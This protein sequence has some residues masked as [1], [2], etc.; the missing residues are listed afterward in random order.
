[1]PSPSPVCV[2]PGERASVDPALRRNVGVVLAVDSLW[3]LGSAAL[4]PGLVVVA[5]LQVHGYGGIAAG[6]IAAILGGHGLLQVLGPWCFPSRA[7]RRARIMRWYVATTV[8]LLLLAGL[9]FASPAGGGW[10]TCLG[11]LAL[12]AAFYVG[13][14]IVAGVYADWFADLFNERVRATVSGMDWCAV[15]VTSAAGA[16]IASAILATHGDGSGYALLFLL[17]GVLC[18][19][20]V[21]LYVFIREPRT[22]RAEA[23]M[24]RGSELL[25]LMRGSLADGVVRRLLVARILGGAAMASGP[26]LLLHFTSAA[27]GGLTAATVIACSIAATI[28]TGVS[29]LG[30]GRMGDRVGHRRSHLLSLA[31]FAAGTA[32]GVLWPGMHGCIAAFLLLGIANGGW[33][34]SGFLVHETTP[35]DSRLAHLIAFH[36]VE[37][38]FGLLLPL[39]WTLVAWRWGVTAPLIASVG[40]AMLALVWSAA[41]VPEPRHR[42]A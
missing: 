34:T 16:V 1:M 20:S 2:A 28:G 18:G 40:V 9:A 4:A 32:T 36:S 7:M 41:T 26:F 10:L 15:S 30:W 22:E 6:V 12:V 33:A 35:H 17:A 39:G 23:P 14:G 37:S 21:L 38:A 31:L 5:F 3:G 29:V 11:V 24:P 8:P 19:G 25:R 27:G 13:Q 42:R